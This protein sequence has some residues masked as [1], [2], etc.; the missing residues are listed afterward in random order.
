MSNRVVINQ[1]GLKV[2]RPGV[3]VLNPGSA[4]LLFNSD[5]APRIL[6]MTGV[7][8]TG[9][10]Q[11]STILYGKTYAATPHLQTYNF[12]PADL[13]P[14]YGVWFLTYDNSVDL[15]AYGNGAVS[16]GLDRLIINNSGNTV[17]VTTRYL[18][19][20]YY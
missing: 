17:T 16:V 14:P 15:G 3:D 1:N 7:V 5:W 19:W 2:S 18:V 9:A 10:G 4:G 8:Y 13:W 20:D 12:I 11:V 6:H